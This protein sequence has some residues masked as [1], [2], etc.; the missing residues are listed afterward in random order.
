MALDLVLRF[1]CDVSDT[2]IADKGFNKSVRDDWLRNTSWSKTHAASLD[3]IVLPSPC[4]FHT[5]ALDLVLGF[6]CDV[7]DT[8]IAEKDDSIS[9]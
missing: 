2:L 4:T 5:T 3:A 9:Q 8:L 7:C 6:L 1:L